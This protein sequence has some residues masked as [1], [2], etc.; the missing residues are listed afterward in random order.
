M[1][2]VLM[3]GLWLGLL[4]LASS[5]RLH[6]FLHEDSHQAHHECVVTF[7]SKGHFLA[8]FVPAAVPVAVFACLGQSR[9]AANSL[10]SAGDVRLAPGRAPP[11]DSLPC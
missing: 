3:L 11:A 9:F 2:G 4:G 5:E 1:A 7:F 8:A 6:H 10:L